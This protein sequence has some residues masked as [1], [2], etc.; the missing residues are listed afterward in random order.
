MVGFE[1]TL[2]TLSRRPISTSTILAILVFRVI[3]P[4]PVSTVRPSILASRSARFSATTSMTFSLRASVAVAET[5]FRTASSAHVAFRPRR[6]HLRGVGG[7]DV[8][9]GGHGGHMGGDG[10]EGARRG[11]PR[12]AG[13]HIDD[14]R[15]RG[16]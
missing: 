1:M 4:A 6:P 11:G 3:L 16:S 5:L 15:G 7:P 8:G 9:S 14:D 10:D 13:G 12:P 2:R